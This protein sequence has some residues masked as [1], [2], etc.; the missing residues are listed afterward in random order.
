MQ[1][2]IQFT[3]E[4]QPK[5]YKAMLGLE[6]YLAQSSISKR[7]KDLVKI[8]ASYINGCA[9]CIDMHTKEALHN[10]ESLQRIFLISSWREATQSFTEEERIVLTITEEVTLIHNHGLR[11]ETYESAL[12]FFSGDQVAE[13]IMAVVTINA[14]NRIAISTHKPIGS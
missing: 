10:G 13:I 3:N 12:R 14:R 9:Y 1:E 2:R 4:E 7:L 8:R 6:A 5:A 11:D